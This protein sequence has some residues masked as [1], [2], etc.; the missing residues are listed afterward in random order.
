[1]GFPLR[2]LPSFPFKVGSML[3]IT[4]MTDVCVFTLQNPGYSCHTLLLRHV[5]VSVC[6]SS[7]EMAGYTGLLMTD[8]YNGSIQMVKSFRITLKTKLK[9]D[10]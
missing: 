3:N 1:M 9:L 8:F 4:F 6:V 2:T 7:S 5:S 10:L